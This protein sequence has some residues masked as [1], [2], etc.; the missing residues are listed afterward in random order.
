VLVLVFEEDVEI[1]TLNTEDA[2]GWALVFAGAVSC[3]EGEV[4]EKKFFNLL[5]SPD[6]EEL[7]FLSSLPG[8]IEKS[9]VGF[10]ST[11]LFI[12]ALSSLRLFIFGVCM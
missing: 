7:F 10:L 5:L 3:F 12:T 2:L 1:V 8:V 9:C 4:F 11:L 6:F